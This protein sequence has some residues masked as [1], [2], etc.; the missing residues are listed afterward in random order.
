MLPLELDEQ[1]LQDCAMACRV[2]AGQAQ[3]ASEESRNRLTSAKHAD[4]ADR[5]TL[6]AERFEIA[7]RVASR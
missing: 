6:L 7:Q 1:E 3:Q 2:A 5:F 4:E